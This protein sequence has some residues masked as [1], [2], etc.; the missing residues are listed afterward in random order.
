MANIN[1]FIDKSM[2]ITEFRS[3]LLDGLTRESRHFES[4][5]LTLDEWSAVHELK[6]EKYG[7]WDWNFGKSPQ[8]NIKRTHRFTVGEIDL[9]LLVEKGYIKNFKIYGDFFG[10]K[11]VADI[12]SKLKDVRYELASLK[13]VLDPVDI[14]EYFGNIDKQEF[15]NLVYGEDK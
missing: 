4:Y 11:Q 5:R 14:T 13:S 2:D 9:R 10:E 1:E 15:L 6:D 3:Q 7:N 12:E 8:F